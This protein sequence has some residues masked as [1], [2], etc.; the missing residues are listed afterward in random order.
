MPQPDAMPLSDAQVQALHDRANDL[1]GSASA[2]SLYQDWA[3]VYDATIERFGRYL[4]PDRIAAEAARRCPDRSVPVLDVACG[5][6]LAGV[7]LARQ[8][9]SRITGLDL[10]EEMLA[11]AAAKGCYGRLVAA[12]LSGPLPFAPGAFGVI[13]CI[14]ALL[15]GHL[16]CG[17]FV[18]MARMLP[19]GG[20]LLADV[21]G[22]TFEDEGYA[23]A[24]ER[25]QREGV[26][27]EVAQ[28]AGHFHA[29]GQG[30]AMHGWFVVVRRG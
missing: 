29:P 27:A 22:G 18:R 1:T 16:D 14:G 24:L 9:F 11:V 19:P 17:A 25:L 21:E 13:T 4:S 15:A 26:L 20:V 7:A 8:G 5:T 12:D 28:E 23:A 2:R 3:P 10:S 30:E 6:G